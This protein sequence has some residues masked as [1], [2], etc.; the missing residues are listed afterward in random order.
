MKARPTDPRDTRW[1]V[2][3][4]TYRV[5]FWELHRPQEPDSS[6][7]SDEWEIEDA[8]IDEVL[9]WARDTARERRFVVYVS[10]TGGYPDEPGLVRL[11]GTD[12]LDKLSGK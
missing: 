10:L 5:Y 8:D 6:W 9:N 11:L 3:H 1:E 2:P 4:P 7:V 12:P